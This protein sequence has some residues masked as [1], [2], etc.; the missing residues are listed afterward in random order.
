MTGKPASAAARF[1]TLAPPVSATGGFVEL[2]GR[3]HY[4]IAAYQ[5]LEPFLVSLASDT[6]LWLFASS[7]GGL[8]AGRVDPDGALFPYVTVDRLHDSRHHAGPVTIFRCE[9]VGGES[10]LLR[11]FSRTAENRPGLERNL[12]KNTACNRLVFQEIDHEMGLS[13]RYDWAGCDEFGWVR[14]AVLE[15]IGSEPIRIKMLDGVRNVLP[16]GAPLSLY[17]QSGNLV[18]AYKKTEVDPETGMGIFSLTAGITDRAEAREVLRANTVWCSGLDKFQVHLSGSATKAFRLGRLLP[19]ESLLNGARGSYLVS[20]S[21]MLAPGESRRWT[22][23]CDTGLDQLHI[24]ELRRKLREQD[25]MGDQITAALDAATTNL[26]RQVGSADGIQLSG[27]PESW[28]H[29]FANVLFNN[30]RGGV[31]WRNYDLPTEDLVD[32]L[33]VRNKPVAARHHDLLAELPETISAGRLIETAGASGDPDFRR[34]ALEYLPLHFGRRH[35]DPSRPWNTFAIRMRNSAGRQELNYQGNW[36]DIFQ[37]WEA[38]CTAFPG[39]LPNVTAKFLNASTIDGFNPYRLTRNG[40]NW[41]EITPQ[42]P[43]SNIGYWGDHQIVYLLRLLEGLR[44]YDP[45]ALG[46]MLGEAIFSYA[47]VPYR[48]K[49]YA[50]LLRDPGSTIEFDGEKAA[51]IAEREAALGTDGRLL[52]DADGSIRRANML[53]KLLVPALSKLSNLVPEAGIWMNTQRPEWNDANNAL[54]DGGV[55]VVTL[56]HLRRYLEFLAELLDDCAEKKLPLAVEVAEWF[57]GVEAAL[58]KS[59]GRKDDRAATPAERRAVMDALGGAFDSYR[60]K[61]YARGL[62]GAA[63]V[64][65]DRIADFCRL[66]LEIVDRDIAANRR[67]DGLFHSYNRLNIMPDGGIGITRLQEMLEGQV[68]VISSGLLEPQQSL[69]ILE[70]MFAGDLYRPDQHTFMLYPQRELPGF[71][72][73]NSVPDDLCSEIP[74]LR[75]MLAAGDGSIIARDADGVLRFA[76]G[77]GNARDLAAVLDELGREGRWAAAARRDRTAVLDLFE[78]VFDHKSYTGRS[79]V[80]YGYEG[81]GCIYWHMVAK[82]LLAAQETV[83]RAERENRPRALVDDLTAMYLRIRSGLGY[84]KTV[85][86]YGAFPADPYSHTPATGG[87]KQPGMTGQVKEEILTRAGE[88][89]VGIDG[90]AVKFAPV[91]LQ[92]GEFVH[93]PAEF[94]YFDVEGRQCSLDLLPGDLAFT[95]CQVPVVY[96]RKEGSARIRILYADGNTTDLSDNTLDGKASALIFARCGAIERIDV[97]VPIAQTR[98]N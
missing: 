77:Q 75:E 7:D 29:H 91:L 28:T 3:M 96:H 15:N 62:T 82:L 73:K 5:R 44:G 45:Q 37:N 74:L 67:E 63:E 32:F 42:N 58:E 46:G 53:E 76:A 89:G 14:S 19:A 79:G 55:S 18:D 61:V 9:R 93:K 84:N 33:Q 69:D 12:Y 24:A 43:W 87:A 31:F 60:A 8:T 49:P 50:D 47:D 66:A 4:R 59:R 64:R 97:D 39:F 71:M 22:M 35:G 30:M 94:C 27:R 52:P 83:F 25:D 95:F 78:Q 90:G 92:A 81:L 17:Q 98:P 1:Q 86:E 54:A 13:F 38:L 26:E 34:L 10:L 57:D 51:L 88:L 85:V 65:I 2:D 21:M 6:D 20:T 48:I 40:V 16:Y 36:R 80:M 72:A 41:E 68:A 56:C 11:P 23:A 70:R